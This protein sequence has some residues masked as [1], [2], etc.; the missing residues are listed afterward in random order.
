MTSAARPK[1]VTISRRR[2]RHVEFES[3]HGMT[4][5]ELVF[6]AHLASLSRSRKIAESLWLHVIRRGLLR[7]RSTRVTCSDLPYIQAVAEDIRNGIGLP[8]DP[9]RAAHWREE[10][11]YVLQEFTWQRGLVRKA[12]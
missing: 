11:E 6:Q 7:K 4:D 2:N 8:H 1:E 3:A 10:A 5:K 12:R 9:V